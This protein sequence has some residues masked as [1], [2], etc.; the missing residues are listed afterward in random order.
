MT[1]SL[2]FSRLVII[3]GLKYSIRFWMILLNWSILN[4]FVANDSWTINWFSF[5]ENEVDKFL[6]SLYNYKLVSMNGE[7]L[8]EVNSNH[9]YSRPDPRK[10]PSIL[11][12]VSFLHE[13]TKRTQGNFFSSITLFYF[14]N[15]LP[16]WFY[17]YSLIYYSNDEFFS[18]PR[19]FSIS[20]VCLHRF[21]A[22]NFSLSLSQHVHAL[23]YI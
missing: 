15:F 11:S 7:E 22:Q 17:V 20:P 2:F 19:N 3:R 16:I 21:F 23:V 5:Q 10:L 8:I 13:I 4:R 12:D 1:I 6:S 9:Q 14:H 18:F